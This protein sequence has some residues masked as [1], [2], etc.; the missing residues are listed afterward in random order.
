MENQS[1]LA[2]KKGLI[3]LLGVIIGLLVGVAITAVL[4]SKLNLR[5]QQ[6]E[7]Q[8]PLPPSAGSTDTI[9][10]YIVHKYEPESGVNKSGQGVDS[11]MNDSLYVDDGSMDYMLD[12]EDYPMYKDA[13]NESVASERVI[14]KQEVPVLYFDAGKNP[15]SAPDNAPKFMEV[16]FWSTPIHNKIVYQFDNN[17]LKIKGLKNSD[18]QIIHFNGHYYLQNEKRVYQIVPAADFR[19]LVEVRDIS[20]K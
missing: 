15:I 9:Y 19:R 2:T 13:E 16:Q 17:V 11:L 4:V 14:F 10:K 12:D 8:Q 6:R 20:F 7:T 3:L 1:N 18:P 5:Q